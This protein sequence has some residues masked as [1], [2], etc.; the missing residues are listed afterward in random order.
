MYSL[1][2]SARLKG[3]APEAYLPYVLGRIGD[4]IYRGEKAVVATDIG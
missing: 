2:G 1:I 4:P 3:L